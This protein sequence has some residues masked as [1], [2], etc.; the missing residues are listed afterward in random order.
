MGVVIA[1]G[2]QTVTGKIAGQN[3]DDTGLAGAVKSRLVAEEAS[4][5][6]RVDVDIER[7]VVYLT[8]TVQSPEERRREEARQYN[9]GGRRWFRFY[10]GCVGSH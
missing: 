4:N 6:T 3:V 9:R 2:C 10:C 5:V 8:G 7:G 1:A